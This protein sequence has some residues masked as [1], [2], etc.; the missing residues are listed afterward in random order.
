MAQPLRFRPNRDASW[1]NEFVRADM[2]KLKVLESTGER[3]IELGV[4][5]VTIGRDDQCTVPLATERASREH[6]AIEPVAGGYKIV[7]LGSTN[8]TRVNGEFV[9]QKKLEPGDRIEIGSALLVFDPAPLAVPAPVIAPKPRAIEPAAPQRVAR[10]I[11]PAAPARTKAPGLP[12][13]P[14]AAARSTAPVA[15]RPR[16]ARVPTLA[17]PPAGGR[18]RNVLFLGAAASIA[19]ALTVFILLGKKPDAA[20]PPLDSPVAAAPAHAP[21]TPRAGELPP[22]VPA[23]T[24]ASG[25]APAS[26]LESEPESRPSPAPDATGNAV[27]AT[28]K[29]SA[30]TTPSSA[31]AAPTAAEHGH[32]PPLTKE[33]YYLL[34]QESEAIAR[35]QAWTEAIGK[36]SPAIASCPFSDV[37]AEMEGHV[38]DWRLCADLLAAVVSGVK[39]SS[40]LSAEGIGPVSG[41]DDGGVMLASGAHVGW[42]DVK[43][44]SFFDLARRTKLEP[45]QTLGLAAYA[46]ECELE[47]DANL[48]LE[49][50]AESQP[51][52]KTDIDRLLSR[53]LMVE[54]PE[55]GFVVFDHRFVTPS[56][57][58]QLVRE[59][60][61]TALVGKL[62][63][64]K[65]EERH[66]IASKLRGYGEPGDTLLAKT[67]LDEKTKLTAKLAENPLTKR[68]E[69]LEKDRKK[70]DQLRE[71]ALALIFD[72]VKYP[73]PYKP[74]AAPPEVYRQYMETQKEVNRRVDAVRDAWK[75]AEQHPVALQP[76]WVGMLADWRDVGGILRDL[77][78][79]FDPATLPRCLA[80]VDVGA[81]DV[82]IRTCFQ[83]EG[84]LEAHAYTKA[85]L[86]WNASV[87]PKLDKEEV[88]QIRITNEYRVMMGRRAVAISDKLVASAHK[89][90]AEMSR[91][92]Y[93]DH[94]SPTPELKTPDMRMRA[95]GY[96]GTDLSENIA[97][98]AQ[99]AEAAHLAW[100]QSSGHHRNIL[101]AEWSEMGSGRSGQYWTQNFGLSA[102]FVKKLLGR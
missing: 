40:G 31:E 27:A 76:A 58:D 70:L 101:R 54:V 49:R 100:L 85:A 16:P 20:T 2:P 4:R 98:G 38:V 25:T 64:A 87:G 69:S 93:F 71:N 91:L 17:A 52:L 19:A 22:A 86:D 94:E 57:R 59:A 13:R 41:A 45:K 73:Y 44:R 32:L 35:A 79:D 14:A 48:V 84:E 5:V 83:S 7:D 65:T 6:C 30:G 43:P 96:D 36:L 46:F 66:A 88:E 23:S 53:H 74:P 37:K 33:G 72:E 81:K 75:A 18:A 24:V 42:R 9:A 61:M 34:V 77:G 15:E 47:A 82:S 1:E 102:A 78:K 21:E 62:A 99:S 68:V 29:P 26:P 55:G 89:H 56:R 10:E 11:E 51:Q 95:E 28:E 3:A 12:P 60:D 50:L 97:G 8:G 39:G 63:T 92:G 90:S 67:L 80:F